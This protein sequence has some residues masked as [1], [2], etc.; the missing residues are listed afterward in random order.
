LGLKLASLTDLDLI[1][2][3]RKAAQKIFDKDPDLSSQE[4]QLLLQEL[5]TFWPG[6]SG[7]VS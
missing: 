4:N 1:L 2:R 7:D 6:K 5:R 3:A